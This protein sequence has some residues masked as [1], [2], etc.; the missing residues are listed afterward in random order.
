MDATHPYAGQISSNA[1]DAA[2][3]AG[4]PL[5]VYRRPSWQPRTGDD[6]RYCRGWD[7]LVD[8]LATFRRPFFTVGRTPLENLDSVAPHQH[9][10]VRSLE[11]E[12]PVHPRLTAICA[13]GP[14]VE[15]N[16]L[17]LMREH[18]VD[19]LV[20][21]NSGGCAVAAKLAAA[22]A[23]GL[24]VLMLERPAPVDADRSFQRI[25]DLVNAVLS[26]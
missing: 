26:Q 3:R 15:T 20:A 24:P 9:W 5:W 12:P 13:R 25:G 19:V 1:S 10:V 8:L 21:K 23:L 18:R 22:R 14:F 2:R 6:W 4:I 11:T 17:Q 7:G 16:E